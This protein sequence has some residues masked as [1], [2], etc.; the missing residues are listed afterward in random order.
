MAQLIVGSKSWLVTDMFTPIRDGMICLL[1]FRVPKVKYGRCGLYPHPTR[2]LPSCSCP[3]FEMAE[4]H[5]ATS[6]Q[7]F[8]LDFIVKLNATGLKVEF[9]LILSV[10]VLLRMSENPSF[11][12]PV[13]RF[14]RI[15]F[16]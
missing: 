5:Q 11:R 10:Y 12:P 9:N 4:A 6:G 7:Y 2:D 14:R 3:L 15:E 16:S 8:F 13:S 1:N